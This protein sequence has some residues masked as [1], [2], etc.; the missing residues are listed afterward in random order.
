MLKMSSDIKKSF[1]IEVYGTVA[2]RN[3][4]GYENSHAKKEI[5]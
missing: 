4:E 2:I 5:A 3:A 1:Y